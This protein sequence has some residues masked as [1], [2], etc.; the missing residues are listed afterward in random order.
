MYKENQSQFGDTQE[1]T[2]Q[3]NRQNHFGVSN[4]SNRSQ[5][6]HQWDNFIHTSHD[7][8]VNT[9]R[10]SKAEVHVK[11]LVDHLIRW[12]Q[13]HQAS[14][15]ASVKGLCEGTLTKRT[16]SSLRA[17]LAAYQP[18][19]FLV[20][21]ELLATVEEHYGPVPDV[22]SSADAILTRHGFVLNAVF[23]NGITG[24]LPVGGAA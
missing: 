9:K 20:A 1:S 2:N 16:A 21:S 3:S 7:V 18:E 23:T 6:G 11:M 15:T 19:T 17:I 22:L 8:T 24:T 4:P 14:I 12:S 13:D 10:K 5:N